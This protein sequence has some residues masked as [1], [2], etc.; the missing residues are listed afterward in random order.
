[1]VAIPD[2]TPRR[3]GRI[4]LMT[5]QEIINS[6]SQM[7]NRDL[8]ATVVNESLKDFGPVIQVLLDGRGALIVIPGIVPLDE[9]IK[10]S[11]G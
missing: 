2:L 10:R 8:P 6:L 3:P 1:M 7:P 11:E 4:S 9:S 5:I